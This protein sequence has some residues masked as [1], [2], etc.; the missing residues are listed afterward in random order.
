MPAID[1]GDISRI[2]AALYK[3]RRN[4]AGALVAL[5]RRLLLR[6]PPAAAPS[7]RVCAHALTPFQ[8]AMSAGGKPVENVDES[9]FMTLG[10]WL[11][12]N[13]KDME[14][15]VARGVADCGMLRV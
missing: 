14:V 4:Q 8:V 12:S 15:R 13:T 6:P 1:T 2:S 3:L 9:D 10:R 5:R 11:M 7:P